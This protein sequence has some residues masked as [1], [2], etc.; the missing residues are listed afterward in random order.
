MEWIETRNSGETAGSQNQLYLEHFLK[1]VA[2][3]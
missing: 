3:F 2:V 1:S